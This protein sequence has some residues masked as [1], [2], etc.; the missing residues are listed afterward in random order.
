MSL[1]FAAITPHSP[2]LHE[3]IGKKAVQNFKATRKALDKIKREL[4][5]AHLDTLFVLS[6]HGETAEHAFMLSGHPT[7]D[8]HLEAFGDLITQR[9][10]SVD[11]EAVSNM[12]EAG[13]KERLPFMVDGSGECDY[14]TAV[15]LLHMDD[16][17]RN[18]KIVIIRSSQLN[19]KAHLDCG[20]ILKGIAMQSNKRI[21]VLA[22]IDLSHALT[23]HS[24]AG[25]N[26]HAEKF[27]QKIQELVLHTNAAGLMNINPKLIAQAKTCAYGPLMMLFGMLSRIKTKPKILAYEAPHGVG[28]MTAHFRL[29]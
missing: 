25:F 14:A 5:I 20:Y 12:R 13:K 7:V 15:P 17:L 27:D 29:H 16:A 4:Y 19:A 21:G 22:S 2:L 3:P 9:T 8:V 28:H 11:I 18:T 10:F 23:S 1:Y 6:P 26:K 24:P